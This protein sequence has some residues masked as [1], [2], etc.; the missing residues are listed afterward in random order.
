MT[1]LSYIQFGTSIIYEKLATLKQK[2]FRCLKNWFR[3][4]SKMWLFKC[5]I[6]L[7]Y[8]VVRILLKLIQIQKTLVIRYNLPNHKI[9]GELKCCNSF[10]MYL[11]VGTSLLVAMHDDIENTSKTHLY[12]QGYICF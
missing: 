12:M 4:I 8:T 11:P 1:S 6:P 2:R 5:G 9:S 10:W 7:Y 3:L